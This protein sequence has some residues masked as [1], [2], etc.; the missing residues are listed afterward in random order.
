MR[1]PSLF[2]WW[3]VWPVGQ[4]LQGGALRGMQR[5]TEPVQIP[6]YR[7]RI[8]GSVRFCNPPGCLFKQ[9]LTIAISLGALRVPAA[10]PALPGT[11]G[12]INSIPTGRR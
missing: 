5:L 7:G 6:L 9:I 10:E 8:L 2:L 1:P 3:R 11:R 4:L 12:R